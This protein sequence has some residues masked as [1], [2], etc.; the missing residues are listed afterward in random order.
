MRE[1]SQT[2]SPSPNG[3]VGSGTG[4]T[5]AGVGDVNRH[6]V[7]AGGGEI[8]VFMVVHTLEPPVH[9]CGCIPTGLVDGLRFVARVGSLRTDENTGPA[10]VHTVV[11]HPIA[12]GIVVDQNLGVG[13]ILMGIGHHPLLHQ[14]FNECSISRITF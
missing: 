2:H 5:G 3:Q 9:R 13:K 10:V 1:D 6:I 14:P 7:A 12:G 11:V 4:I 8:E